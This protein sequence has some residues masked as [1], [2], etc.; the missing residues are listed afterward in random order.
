[1]GNNEE[2][3]K[4]LETYRGGLL[5]LNWIFSI[6]LI[7]VGFVMMD[8]IGGLAFIII[9]IAVILGIIGHFMVNV[10]LAVPFILLNNGDYLAAMTPKSDFSLEIKTNEKSD[11][12]RSI[13]LPNDMNIKHN[14][15]TLKKTREEVLNDPLLR[16]HLDF[17]LKTKGEDAFERRI[18]E[19]M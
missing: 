4:R 2:I 17:I 9:V 15:D 7:I 14:A 11:G 12:N 1:M 6:A 5:V 18:M 8:S 10:A 19:L 3:K 16:K 13:E